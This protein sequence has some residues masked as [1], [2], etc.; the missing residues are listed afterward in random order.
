MDSQDFLF[1]S[2]GSGFLV[3]VGFISYAALNLSKTLQ[4]LTSILTKVDSITK[5]VESLKDVIKN[6][7]F[8]LTSMFSKKGGDKNGNKK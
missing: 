7:I 1:Y 6:G 2:L 8:Y 3:L 5:D 4:E